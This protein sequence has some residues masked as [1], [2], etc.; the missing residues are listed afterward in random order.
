LLVLLIGRGTRLAPYIDGEPKVYEASIVFGAETTT[1]DLTGEITRV[2]EPPSAPAVDGAIASLT[3]SILQR[4]PDYSAKQ[5]AG[6]R[7][8]AAARSGSSLALEAVPVKV[9]EWRVRRRASAELDATITCGAGTYVRAL[10]RDLGRAAGSAAH[11][12]AL[13][14]IRSGVFDVARAVSL[15]ALERGDVTLAP[16]RSAIPHLPTQQLAGDELRRARHGNSV[17]ARIDAPLVALL[18][19]DGDLVGIARRDQNILHPSV[20]M[21]E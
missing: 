16:L 21:H 5:V 3:G 19:A 12:A 14:R 15:V 6:R 17:D 10:A 20:V 9:Y 7:A 4:P 2:A 1:D 11:L 13:R 8:Y 18:D